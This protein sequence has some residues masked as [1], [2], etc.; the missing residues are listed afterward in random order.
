LH[1]RKFTERIPTGQYGH[2][3]NPPSEGKLR[4]KTSDGLT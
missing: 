2:N 4:G 3:A 1:C